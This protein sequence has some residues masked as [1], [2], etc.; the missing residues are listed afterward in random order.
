MRAVNLREITQD[1]DGLPPA[2]APGP[3]PPAG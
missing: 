2:N 3:K 1:G